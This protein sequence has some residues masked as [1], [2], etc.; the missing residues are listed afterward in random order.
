MNEIGGTLETIDIAGILRAIP[1][2]YPF[3]LVDRI[4]G[5]RGDDFA[6][7]LSGAGS[8]GSVGIV[9]NAGIAAALRTK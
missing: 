9:P 6:I 1:H 5:I 8:D 4:V 7:V 3:L 2:R